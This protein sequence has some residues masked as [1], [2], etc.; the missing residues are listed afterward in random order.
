MPT[1]SRQIIEC[2]MRKKAYL[3]ATNYK[4]LF[5]YISNNATVQYRIQDFSWEGR[6]LPKWVC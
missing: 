3:E 4:L 5:L 2:Y 1:G 6:Q